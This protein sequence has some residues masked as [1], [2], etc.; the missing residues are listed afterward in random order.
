M[1]G[2]PA[3]RKTSNTGATDDASKQLLYCQSLNI[4]LAMAAMM[5]NVVLDC[6]TTFL[7]TC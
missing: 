1:A 2:K 3:V 7:G 5:V 6:L 4:L